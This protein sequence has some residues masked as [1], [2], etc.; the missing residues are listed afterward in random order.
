MRHAGRHGSSLLLNYLCCSQ[1]STVVERVAECTVS[2]PGKAILSTCRFVIPRW[3]WHISSQAEGCFEVKVEE[4]ARVTRWRGLCTAYSRMWRRSVQ[5]SRRGDVQC[6]KEQLPGVVNHLHEV[7]QFLT[8][9]SGHVCNAETEL[10][11]VR[12]HNS[13]SLY[14]TNTQQ[15]EQGTHHAVC[16]RF[17]PMSVPVNTQKMF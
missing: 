1:R 6:S 17:V 4:R 2:S 15:C 8:N 10:C 7:P 9:P 13:C 3:Q 14:Q 11:W 5:S 12:Q 16:R